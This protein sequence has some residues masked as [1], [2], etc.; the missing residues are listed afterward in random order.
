VSRALLLLFQVLSQR[1]TAPH[2]ARLSSSSPST[3]SAPVAPSVSPL[4]LM[5]LIHP[6]SQT[7]VSVSAV[8]SVPL[9]QMGTAPAPPPP[10]AFSQAALASLTVAHLGSWQH[11]RGIA[12]SEHGSH[13]VFQ[14][15]QQSARQ[16]YSC[17]SS[18]GAAAAFAAVPPSP[19]SVAQPPSSTPTQR[20]LVLPEEV[21]SLT[22]SRAFLRGTL[23]QQ[24]GNRSLAVL[25]S[26]VEKG[27]PDGGAAIGSSDELLATCKVALLEA[28]AGQ[29]SQALDH[30]RAVLQA[31]PLHY[32]HL[33]CASV[34]VCSLMACAEISLLR[35]KS[36]C[37]LFLLLLQL[38]SL[39]YSLLPLSLLNGLLAEETLRLPQRSCASFTLL[40]FCVT[41]IPFSITPS[42]SCGLVFFRP[43]GR[44]APRSPVCRYVFVV[45]F[46]PPLM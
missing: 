15:L 26:S 10:E 34:R 13:R 23:W 16:T 28:E 17:I 1:S 39:P 7:P 30:L 5:S 22:S 44:L 32:K 38:P 37:A 43:P 33:S 42:T 35:Y 46:L 9:P 2:N 6:A 45:V 3:A 31:L 36:L 12:A 14:Y 21:A 40:L 27:T 8:P 18:A 19:P 11:A 24:F 4:P 25:N 20:A 29:Y 41:R